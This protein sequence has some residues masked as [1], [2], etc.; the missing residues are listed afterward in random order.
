MYIDPESAVPVEMLHRIERI[1][2]LGDD[3]RAEYVRGPRLR[4]R[5]GLRH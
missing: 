5:R 3:R 4:R 1:P 2:V